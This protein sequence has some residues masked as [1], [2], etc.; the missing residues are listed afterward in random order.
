M[1]SLWIPGK[2]QGVRGAIREE[3]DDFLSAHKRSELKKDA[4]EG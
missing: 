2:N 4:S 1:C 3:Q